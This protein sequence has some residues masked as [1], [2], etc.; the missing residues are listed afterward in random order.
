MRL[1]LKEVRLLDFAKDEYVFREGESCD[2]F[3]LLVE[4]SVRLTKSAKLFKENPNTLYCNR[5][6]L[7]SGSSRSG[8]PYADF[9]LVYNYTPKTKVI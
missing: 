1:I 2:E 3:Y 7:T 8:L 6:M 9:S 4:G 5:T